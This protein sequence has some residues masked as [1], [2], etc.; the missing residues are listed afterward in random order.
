MGNASQSKQ[1]EGATSTMHPERSESELDNL[2]EQIETQI[3]DIERSVDLS[4]D[5]EAGANFEE[6]EDIEKMIDRFQKQTESRNS[7]NANTLLTIKVHGKRLKDLCPHDRKWQLILLCAFDDLELRNR[8]GRGGLNGEHGCVWCARPRSEI[9]C[10]HEQNCHCKQKSYPIFTIEE[11]IVWGREALPITLLIT[12]KRKL[13][14][15]LRAEAKQPFPQKKEEL[16]KKVAAIDTMLRERLKPFNGGKEVTN[17][18]E[19]IKHFY[20]ERKGQ[21]YPPVFPSLPVWLYAPCGLHMY[22]NITKTLVKITYNELQ[23]TRLSELFKIELQKLHLQ[24]GKRLLDDAIFLRGGQEKLALIGRDCFLIEKRAPAVL[25]TFRQEIVRRLGHEDQFYTLSLDNLITLW[26]KWTRA[27]RH[28]WAMSPSEQE[29]NSCKEDCWGFFRHLVSRFDASYVTWY[30]HFLAYHVH[31]ATKLLYE[32][33]HVGYGVMTTQATEH[34]HKWLKRRLHHTLKNRLMWMLA[35][36]HQYQQRSGWYRDIF[37]FPCQLRRC[38]ACH[39]L[40]HQRNNKCCPK[41][42]ALATHHTS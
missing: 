20:N 18:Q 31:E 6:I 10:L 1:T 22:V 21:R 41:R 28:I 37:K 35:L 9:A 29:I 27:S 25:K 34:L 8:L 14:E 40:G 26:G 15:L 17:L 36:T 19:T 3:R 13:A 33:F 24:Y 39:Q 4:N 38:S 7:R 11:L 32:E 16:E 30:I 23:N 42:L 2:A 5:S 12:R